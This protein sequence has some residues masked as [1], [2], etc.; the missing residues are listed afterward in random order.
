M[1]IDRRQSLPRAWDFSAVLSQQFHEQRVFDRLKPLARIAIAVGSRGIK[2]LAQI[3]SCV[4]DRL[5][6]SGMQSFIVPAMGS[7]GGA[8]TRMDVQLIGTSDN[9]VEVFSAKP[10]SMLM[11]WL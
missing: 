11:V 7:H 4:I 3:V 5:H 8:D 6:K 10:L 9:G 1:D 2:N